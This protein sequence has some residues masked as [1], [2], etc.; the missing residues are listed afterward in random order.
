MKKKKNIMDDIKGYLI[1]GLVLGSLIIWGI[2]M[3][4][5]IFT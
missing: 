5:R 4:M 3:V 2:L 1:T